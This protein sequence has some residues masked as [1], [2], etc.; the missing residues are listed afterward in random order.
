MG[1]AKKRRLRERVGAGAHDE[2]G[3]SPPSGESAASITTPVWML[4]FAL[5]LAAVFSSGMLVAQHFLGGSVPGCGEGGACDR[6]AAS[7]W[8][9]IP[10]IDW[11]VSF[12]GLAYF[13]GLLAAWLIVPRDGVTR[14][15]GLVRLGGLASI[16]YLIVIIAGGYACPYCLVSHAGNLGFLALLETQRPRGNW[17]PRAFLRSAAVQ[18]TAIG[19]VAVTVVLIGWNVLAEQRA[20]EREDRALDEATR[21]IAASDEEEG[22]AFTGRYR[23]GPE[24]AAIRIVAFTGYQCPECQRFEHEVDR[25]LEERDDLSFSV[26]H[27]PINPDCNPHVS[28]AMHPNACWAARAAEAAGIL[29]GEEGFWRMHDWLVEQQGG[30]TDAVLNSKLREL[31]YDPR[32]FIRVMMGDETL[33]LVREDADEAVSL[34]LAYTPMVFINGVELRNTQASRTIRRAVQEI[35]A[36]NPEPRSPASDRPPDALT[37]SMEEWRDNPVRTIPEARAERQFGDSDAPV[38]IEVWGD[39]RHERT[40]ALDQMIRKRLDDWPDVRYAFRSFPLDESCNDLLSSTAHE[41]GCLIAAALEAAADVGGRPGYHALHEWI[42]EYDDV[43]TGEALAEAVGQF[44]MDEDEWLER[45]RSSPVHEAVRGH[46]AIVD[47][48]NTRLVV[49]QLFIDGRWAPRFELDDA[50]LLG[51]MVNEARAAQ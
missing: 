38:R 50:D 36:M 30:F 27:F 2:T 40:R 3:Q 37:R 19:F 21:Q 26:K 20:Q 29:G 13:V 10:G 9:S 39:Y 25:L 43:V 8:G 34:G 47:E 33:R 7:V 22:A 17:F 1:S 31:G 6:A 51:T 11:P 35:A 46:I 5:L 44:G 28:R 23:R 48:I 49:P 41:S 45:W 16:F 14:L 24:R 15:R 18:R 42:I 4:G 32:E 12:L